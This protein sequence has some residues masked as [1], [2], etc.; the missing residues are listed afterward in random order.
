MRVLDDSNDSCRM[1]LYCFPIE[2]IKVAKVCFRPCISIEIRLSK[3]EVSYNATVDLTPAMAKILLRD[4]FTIHSDLSAEAIAIRLSLHIAPTPLISWR[5][6]WKKPPRP[7]VGE[8]TP[9]SFSAT[10]IIDHKNS[11]LPRIKGN[12]ES[13][14]NGT[15]IHVKMAP[16]LWVLGFSSFS[17]LFAYGMTLPL[18]LS[19]RTSILTLIFLGL[20]IVFGLVAWLAF[21]TEVRRSRKDLIEFTGGRLQQPQSM[22]SLGFQIETK[23]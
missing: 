12:F 17:V 7:Y 21:W 16:N 20:P 10:R 1:R 23:S 9:S 6:P 14:G 4:S 2:R 3:A 19:A 13:L 18:Y 8:V 22:D 15:A 11:F 5:W